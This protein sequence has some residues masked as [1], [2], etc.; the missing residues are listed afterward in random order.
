M[1]EDHADARRS[2]AASN[3]HRRR[4]LRHQGR[5]PTRPIATRRAPQRVRPHEVD[6]ALRRRAADDREGLPL[7][8]VMPGLVYGPGTAAGALRYPI[9]SITCKG[10]CR[11]CLAGRR[12]AGAT[13][14]NTG[15]LATCSR[16]RRGAPGESYIITGPRAHVRARL[17]C[18]R[19]VRQRARAARAPRAANHAQRCRAHEAGGAAFVSLPSAL[20]P[21]GA[22]GAGRHD[23]TSDPATRPCASWA[24]PPARSRRDWPRR[25]N[26][27]SRA[28]GRA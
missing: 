2:R 24:L 1:L 17:R 23:I 21:G 11:W 26:T 3:Q 19:Q 12:S 16:W 5:R 15:A 27:D 22:A 13:W 10:G 4:V 25:S 28:I 8:I 18:C 6:R 9:R 7:V 20:Q 14:T